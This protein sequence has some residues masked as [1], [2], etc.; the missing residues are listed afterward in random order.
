[1]SK[2][3]LDEAGVNPYS[4]VLTL[5]RYRQLFGENL[6]PFTLVDYV[7]YYSNLVKEEGAEVEVILANDCRVILDYTKNVLTCDIHTRARSKRLLWGAGAERVC[8]LDDILTAPVDGSGYNED[9][10]LLGSNKATEEKVKLFPRD[11]QTF[12]DRTQKFLV[13]ATGKHIEVMIYGDGAFHGGDHFGAGLL[14]IDIDIPCALGQVD[15]G[16]IL[17]GVKDNDQVICGLTFHAALDLHGGHVGL[18][19]Q[20]GIVDN[21]RELQ[22]AGGFDLPH[23]FQRLLR[24]PGQRPVG[25]CHEDHAVI[26]FLHN[27][28][29]IPA[30]GISAP[31]VTADVHNAVGAFVRHQTV[32]FRR[33]C[34]QIH[35]GVGKLGRNQ[36]DTCRFQH[37]SG[38]FCAEVG[39]DDIQVGNDHILAFL[40]QLQGIIDSDIGL[41]AAVMTCK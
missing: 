25:V 7:E 30:Q 5:E 36:L 34:R 12:V 31:V 37:S 32:G 29:H 11:G 20:I 1:M 38:I 15:G 3:K 9:Y 14:A 21:V 17:V 23:H 2:D 35:I 10:G 33:Q 22:T 19:G 26:V 4:D 18:S 6:H 24:G 8:G 16:C 27:G 41:A 13:E 28:G 39:V 40:R